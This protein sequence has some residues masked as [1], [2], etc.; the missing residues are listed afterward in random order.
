MTVRPATEADI[1]AVYEV[2]VAANAAD[3]SPYPTTRADLEHVLSTPGL[4]LERDVVVAVEDGEIVG[5]AWVAARAAPMGEGGRVSLQGAVHPDHRGRGH[6]TELMAAQRERFLPR[7]AQGWNVHG[8]HWSWLDDVAQLYE[9][10]GFVAARVFELM[11]R[12]IVDEDRSLD[13]PDGVSPWD[14]ARSDDVRAILNEAF[15]DHY[16][17]TPLDADE[18]AH[19]VVG[20]GFLPGLSW[21]V[22]EDGRLVG[23]AV[24]S[25]FPEDAATT[26]RREAWLAR[27]GVVPTHR[28][29]G[30]ASAMITAF[31]AAAAHH[32]FTHAA[33]AVDRDSATS[34]PSLYRRHGFETAETTVSQRWDGA[35]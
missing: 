28:N 26:G 7:A 13:V 1:E 8:G 12:P 24:A 33:L 29:R 34:A 5:F 3:R 32:D 14:S 22:E 15:A 2:A 35:A 19:R 9:D 25:W 31:L 21:V 30:L 4:E 10:N 18:W 16:A 20:D 6:G 27:I 11:R 23:A 17:F